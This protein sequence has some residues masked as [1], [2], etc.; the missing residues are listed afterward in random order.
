M[1][2]T[3]TVATALICG[4]VGVCWFCNG[5]LREDPESVQIASWWGL[6]SVSL[7]AY[8]MG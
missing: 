4:F 5:M 6:L 2:R 1:T 3:I 7:L 8:L